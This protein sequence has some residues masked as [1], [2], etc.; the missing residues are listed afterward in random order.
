MSNAERY[1]GAGALALLLLLPGCEESSTCPDRGAGPDAG[2]RG[3]GGKDTPA[4]TVATELGVPDRG[5]ARGGGPSA[6]ATDGAD[7]STP[8][9]W[10]PAGNSWWRQR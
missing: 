7:H 3:H 1:A 5:A 9:S 8:S 4:G 6:A 10:T 2:A